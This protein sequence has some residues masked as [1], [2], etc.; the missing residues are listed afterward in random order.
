MDVEEFLKRDVNRRQFLDRSARNAA[1]MAAGV[2]GL[3]T[4]MSLANSSPNERVV[5]AGIG[6]RGQG[7]F[8]TT[9]MAGFPDVRFKTI[10]DVDDSVAPA[11]I[12]SIEKEQGVAPQFVKDFRQVLDDPEID[13]VVIATPDHWHA[14]MAIM[15]CQAGKDVYVEKPVSH[16]L[17]E[18][19][20]IVEAARKHERVVQ[21]GIHQRSGSHFQ[22]A[23]EYVQSGKLGEVKLAKA[24]I[25]HRRKP[26]GKKKNSTVPAGVNYDLW[27]GPAANR[28][29]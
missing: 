12:K 4:N 10:C 16:N 22:S 20:K 11:A 24:W 25:I 19:L 3:T 2:V 26:I 23:V 6:V 5:L 7:K 28:P 15:A 27:L 9:S 29:F 17:T 1:G 8:L 18:G 21:S 14:L 13:G